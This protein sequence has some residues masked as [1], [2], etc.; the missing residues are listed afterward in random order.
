[1]AVAG[2]DPETQDD[3]LQQ[4]MMRARA[5]YANSQGQTATDAQQAQ[6]QSDLSRAMTM[7]AYSEPDVATQIQSG[8]HATLAPAS[9]ADQPSAKRVGQLQ[10]QVT[11]LDH[12]AHP[13]R[14]I[15]ARGLASAIPLALSAATGRGGTALQEAQTQANQQAIAEKE[16]RR[17]SLVQQMGQAQQAQEQEYGADIQARTKANIAAALNLSREQIAG[18]QAG[19]RRDVATTQAGAR[20]TSAQLSNEARTLAAELGLQGKE[21]EVQAALDRLQYSND[22]QDTRQQRGI[23]AG[24]GRLGQQEQFSLDKPT[25]SEDQR[26]D[27]ADNLNHNLDRLEDIIKRRPDLFGKVQGNVMQP[28]RKRFGTKDEDAGELATIMDNIGMASQGAHQLRNGY[29]V[30]KI[31]SDITNASKNSP[32]AA[33]RA[34]EAS[35]ASVGTFM[36]VQRPTVNGAPTPT[37]R[38]SAPPTRKPGGGGAAKP[39]TPLAN[40]VGPANVPDIMLNGKHMHYTGKGATDDMANWTEVKSG[41]TQR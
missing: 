1:M 14:Q 25:A 38:G 27:L 28:L 3:D 34:I 10:Q 21:Y 22:R 24:F 18:T 19:A 23:A 6:Q 40:Q 9:F 29:L 32:E 4:Q 36:N 15:L 39:K 20:V 31:G 5:A 17:Q 12:P 2:Y 11:A 16:N 37:G 13:Y 41:A 26:A 33:L 35:R 7:A 8:Q 30:E